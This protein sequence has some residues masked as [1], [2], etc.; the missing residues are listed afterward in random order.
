MMKI[1]EVYQ[2]QEEQRLESIKDMLR[3]LVVYQ[4]SFLRNLQY[5][6]DNLAHV[7]HI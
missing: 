7:T 5:D 1:L 6:V 2:K 4:T 3:K